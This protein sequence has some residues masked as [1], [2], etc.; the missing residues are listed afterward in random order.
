MQ[1]SNILPVFV[2]ALAVTAIPLNSE[3]PD[4]MLIRLL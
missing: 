1:L 2:S 4:G 3:N